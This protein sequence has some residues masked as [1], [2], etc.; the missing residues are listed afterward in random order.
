MNLVLR[1]VMATLI[2]VAFSAANAHSGIGIKV[3]GAYGDNAGSDETWAPS[4][5]TDLQIKLGGPVFTQIG[6]SYTPLKGGNYSTKTGIADVRLLVTPLHMNRTF[7]YLYGGFGISKDMNISESDFVPLVPLGIGLQTT[8]GEQL[9]FQFNCGYNLALSDKLTI[10]DRGDDL[11]RFTQQEHDGF[12]EI[13]IGFIYSISA[14]N[15]VKSS[16]PKVV[17]VDRSI[18][19]TD[20][21]GINDESELS[22]YKTDP[23]KKDTDGDGLSDGDE[24]SK[25]KTDPLKKD[26]DGDGLSD[27]D[28]IYVYKTDPLKEDTDGDGLSDGDE[29]LK[30]KTDPLKKDTD[31]DG[32]SDG[33]EVSRYKTDPLKKDTDGDGLSDADEVLKYKTDPLKRDTDG[34]GLSDYEE[35]MTYFTDPLKIDTDNGGMNDGAEIKANKNPLN[36]DDDLFELKKGKKIVLHGITFESNKS[37][38]MPV[39]VTILE[40]VRESLV[41][42]PD[43]TVIVIGH[44]DSQGNDNYNQNLSLQ[45]A[46]AVKDWLV[47]NNIDSARIKV[48]GK[49]ETEPIATNDTAEGRFKNRRIEFLVE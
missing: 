22:Q 31:G 3:G 28:E 45:R 27:Y 43:V 36:P 7:P 17:S 49:G 2:L 24:I 48:I 30:Y 34:D 46:Q 15:K 18:I 26:T 10:N 12:F 33:D 19:D 20:G 41:V 11:N 47:K 23:Y 39:S 35:V 9:L 1:V 16:S 8:L 38:I 25:Y 32:L 4:L 29:V 5:R 6:L 44:T 13:T 14:K 42:N 40:K 21:D 37:K